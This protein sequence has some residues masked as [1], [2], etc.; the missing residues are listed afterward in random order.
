M[1][2]RLLREA[3]I[4]WAR[5]AGEALI[6]DMAKAKAEEMSDVHRLAKRLRAEVLLRQTPAS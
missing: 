4:P 6:A 1:H 5:S 2:I 3:E